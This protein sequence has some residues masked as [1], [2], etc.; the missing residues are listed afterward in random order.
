MAAT[1]E[2]ISNP[3]PDTH[4]ENGNGNGKTWAKIDFVNAPDLGRSV[5]IVGPVE[6]VDPN[7]GPHPKNSRGELG[8][9]LFN[10]YRNSISKDPLGR[11]GAGTHAADRR[12]VISENLNK[13]PKGDVNPN[14]MLVTDPEPLPLTTILTWAVVPGRTC[15]AGSVS[16]EPLGESVVLPLPSGFMSAICPASEWHVAADAAV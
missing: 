1:A 2:R 5:Q 7:L 8:K 6:P 4:P 10:Y 3:T 16:H 14:R 11:V 9:A 15:Q 13:A 12:N